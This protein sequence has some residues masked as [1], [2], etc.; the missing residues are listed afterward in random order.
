M[1]LYI[2]KSSVERSIFF[3]PSS[4]VVVEYM[5]KNLDDETSL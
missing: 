5:K 3:P 2:T 1:K 4:T